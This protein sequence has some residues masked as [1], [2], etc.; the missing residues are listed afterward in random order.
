MTGHAMARMEVLSVPPHREAGTPA[1]GATVS[2]GS[3]R[4]DYAQRL[5]LKDGEPVRVGSR[6]LDLLI[7]LI[8]Q[9][10]KIVSRHE[11]LDLVWR[12]VVVDE[13]G[14]R[15]HMASLRR[16]LGDGRDGAR[17]IVN[18]AG[19]GY[20]FVAPITRSN[21]DPQ[22]LPPPASRA[23]LATGRVPPPPPRTLIG[24]EAVVSSLS[25]LLLTRRFIS[26]VGSGGI[27]KTTVAA[28]IVQRLRSQ[29]GDENVVFVDFGAISEGKLVA[30]AVV[31]AVGCTISGTDP[32]VELLTFLADKRMLIV[33]DS[34]EHLIDQIS[35][36]ADQLFQRAPGVHLLITSRESLRV[37]GETVHLLSP[38][39]YPVCEFPT[40]SK[41]LETPAVQLFMDRA[42]SG[43]FREELSDI[44]APVVSEICH[45]T[46]GI[47]LA[48]ELVASRVGTYGIHGVANLLAS[49]ME[50]RL[51]GRRNVAPRHRTLEAMLDWSFMLLAEKEQKVLCRLSAFVGL[52][53]MEATCAVA[54]DEGPAHDAVTTVLAN[55]V[56]K[57]LVR[58][59]PLGDAVYYRLLDT[60]RAYAAA[61]LVQAGESEL[62]VKR[63]AHYFAMLFNAIALEQGGGY[64]NMERLAPHIGNVRKA[65][66]WSFSHED[67]RVIGVELA[68][69]AVPLFLGLWLLAECRHWSSL[70]LRDMKG[71]SETTEREVRLLEA[72]ALSSMHTGGNSQEVRAA[73][74]RGLDLTETDGRRLPQIHLIAG[75]N[76]FL[77]R[78]GDFEGALAVAKR[79]VA[80]ARGRDSSPDQAIAE[81][82]LGSGHHLAGD[83]L[84]AWEHY[85][86]GFRIEADIG[87]LDAHVFGFNHRLR[88][89]LGRARVL[90][91][92]GSPK[93]GCQLARAVIDES[94]NASPP[95]NYCICVLY[96][97]PVLLWSGDT[98]S[99]YAPIERALAHAERHSLFPYAGAALALKGE[100]LVMTGQESRGLDDLRQ[101]LKLL[102][103][104]NYGI[105]VPA[106][107]RALARGLVQCG[108]HD[109]A[110]ATIDAAIFTAI[111]VGQKFYLPELLR[112]Q[113]EIVLMSPHRDV[114]ATELSFLAAL[115]HAR[116]QGALGWEL[117]VAVPLA[118]LLR[119]QGRDAEA[120]QL[121]EQIYEAHSERTGTTD[122]ADAK[123]ILESLK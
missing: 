116:A 74:E 44:D 17:Y 62:I 9:A 64:A 3:F 109:E 37:E 105:V 26:I 111:E 117:K 85:E 95:T 102:H 81:W 115:D 10:G 4:L 33:F 106:T 99:S 88:A 40:A 7:A 39:A 57:S 77:T 110:R 69:D 56:D 32:A 76:I 89:L 19:R 29:F 12:D 59:H 93:A 71:R 49:N 63:H 5:L 45:R 114:N 60:T 118:R 82:M 50:L 86:R 107:L 43:G 1:V 54:S 8:D 84:A 92:L 119:E 15:V 51:T 11:L 104:E 91:L 28:A 68:A 52:F 103:R 22:P 48:I 31:S 87:G 38:L 13:A 98:E 46:D 6:A 67:S 79:C 70:A 42:S 80:I 55:L 21:R 58:V 27:G 35:Y 66:E 73:L 34:C 121:L 112:T 123:S 94:A 36:L 101:A 41:A 75:L 108:R 25:E 113:G 2:F 65:L 24:R 16:T 53:T 100:W 30:G 120:F 97:V 83:Q 61:K 90:W 18:V 20:S 96:C 72:F 122:L 23:R 78:I 14:V 47:P